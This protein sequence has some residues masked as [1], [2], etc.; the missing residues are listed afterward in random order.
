M[1]TQTMCNNEY[2]L[3]GEAFKLQD[4]PI[5]VGYLCLKVL[6]FILVSQ[7]DLRFMNFT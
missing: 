3:N 4:G 7:C 1:I 6:H 2:I 5:L